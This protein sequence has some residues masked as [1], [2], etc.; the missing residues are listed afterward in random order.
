[1]NGYEDS[2]EIVEREMREYMALGKEELARRL[3][4]HSPNADAV[5]ARVEEYRL[6]CLTQEAAR[7]EFMLKHPPQALVTLS[8]AFINAGLDDPTEIMRRVE[9]IWRRCREIGW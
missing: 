6:K 7:A 8:A 9:S 4:E 5:L 3:A 1:M 2:A